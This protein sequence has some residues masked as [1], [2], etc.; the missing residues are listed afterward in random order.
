[1]LRWNGANTLLKHFAQLFKILL[2]VMEFKRSW[3]PSQKPIPKKQWP[4]HFLLCVQLCFSLPKFCLHASH[5]ALGVWVAGSRRMNGRTRTRAT[6]TRITWRTS[7]PSS[8]ACGLPSAHLCSR[9]V[10]SCPSKCMCTCLSAGSAPTSG[11]TRTPAM[12]SR[13]S[14]RTSSACSTLSGSLLDPSCSKAVTSPPSE[15]KGCDI[16]ALEFSAFAL[17]YYALSTVEF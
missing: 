6:P 2:S 16:C 1:M 17:Y 9:A 5:D 13:T 14:W 10:T 8:T 12:M 3:P 11:T 7:S 15:H 4:S